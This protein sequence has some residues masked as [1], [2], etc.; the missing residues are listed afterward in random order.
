MSKGKIAA[1]I[2]AV[3]LLFYLISFF[4]A[5]LF[6]YDDRVNGFSEAEQKLDPAYGTAL[7]EYAAVNGLPGLLEKLSTDCPLAYGA[8]YGTPYTYAVFDAAG[9]RLETRANT[10]D[11]VL[12]RDGTFTSFYHG[13]IAPYLT[14]ETETQLRDFVKHCDYRAVEVR[15]VSFRTALGKSGQR[16][17]VPTQMT[18]VSLFDPDFILTL[19]LADG[20]ADLST[21]TLENCLSELDVFALAPGRDRARFARLGE[22]VEDFS[23][24][25]RA[26]GSFAQKAALAGRQGNEAYGV[27]FPEENVSEDFPYAVWRFFVLNRL[28]WT[29]HPVAVGGETYYVFCAGLCNYAQDVLFSKGFLL[30]AGGMFLLFALIGAAVILLLFRILS[31]QERALAVRKALTNAAAHELKTPLA[32][33]QNQTECVLENIAPEKNR[34]YIASVYAEAGRMNGIVNDLLR[35]NRLAEMEKTEKEPFDFAEMLRAEADKYEAFAAAAGATLRLSLPEKFPVTGNR[36]MLALAA[37]NYLSNAVK[38]AAGEKRVSL[39]L[40]TGGRR[41]RLEVYN[42]CTPLSKQAQRDVW[43]VL[44]RGD[45]ARSRAENST[46]L[47]LP[48]C[49]EI[50]KLHR[51]RCGC[52]AETTGMTFWFG[53]MK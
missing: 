25:I 20:P 44:T 5:F 40:K 30:I 19:P 47:G 46:G 31:A 45:A 53:T 42:D 18:L 28:S 49:A 34:D 10:L 14:P 7:N 37:D 27:S 4:L 36:E 16:E 43:N 23:E 11:C 3:V 9:R 32:V 6:F 12:V 50:C 41:F 52:R 24:Q 33:I 13:D 21:D 22:I 8:A 15:E 48:T 1:L 26:H 51:F 35:Y 2:A 39:S 17:L 38:Y 29:V